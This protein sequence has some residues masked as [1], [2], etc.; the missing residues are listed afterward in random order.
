T[1]GV[2][3]TDSAPSWSRDGARI[4]FNCVKDICSVN[5]DGT[6]F[7]QLTTDPVA[8]ANAIFSPVDGKIAFLTARFGGSDVAILEENG[9]ITRVAPG[10]LATQHAWSPAGDRLAFVNVRGPSDCY[11]DL[12]TAWM[13]DMLYT[14]NS[15]G[16]ALREVGE[17]HR[18]RW[19]TSLA[20]QPAAAFTYH[21]SGSACQFDATDSFDP[22]GSVTSYVWSFGDGTTGSGATAAHQYATGKQYN[23][24]L[25]VTDNAGAIGISF[26]DVVANAPPVAS[27]TVSCNGATCTFNSLSSDPDGTIAA[28][29]WDF[30]D[31]SYEWSSVP[32]IIHRYATGT[33]RTA[34][35]ISDNGGLSASAEATV[36]VVNA[37]PVAAFTATCSGLTC[38]L[39]ASASSD[40]DVL[41]YRWDLGNGSS[42]TT[43]DKVAI[44][45]L[46]AAGTYQITLTVTDIAGH[47]ATTSR[48]VTVAPLPLPEIHVGNL[49]GS[50]NSLKNTWNPYVTV[51]MHRDNHQVVSGIQ[52][53]ATWSNGSTQTCATGVDGNCWFALDLIPNKTSVVTLTVTGAVNSMWLYKPAANHDADGNS[54]GTVITVRRR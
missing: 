27:F 23:V 53:S 17:G 7:M 30:G 37:V 28:Y 1:S 39:D 26:H 19:A 54:N 6:N 25:T 21:C 5:A 46:P 34:L 48:A 8:A 9:A 32:V 51:Q 13:W 40:D 16:S 2:G 45:L 49:T 20:G 3:F 36:T 31:G 38:T 43:W 44:R 12:C 52:V 50:A 11:Y 41:Y 35:A 24:K 29:S 14:V 42:W 10:L 15:D 22:D 33:F 4:A 47:T 18:P